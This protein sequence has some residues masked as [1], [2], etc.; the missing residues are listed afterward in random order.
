MEGLNDRD[1]KILGQYAE[2]GNRE[3][4]WNYLA[5]TRGNDGYG[6]LALGVVRNDNMPGAV[7]NIYAENQARDESGRR[8]TEREWDAFGQDLVRRDFAARQKHM[9][10]GD[11]DLAL[12]LPVKDVQ[13]VHDGAFKNAGITPDAWT[14]RQLLEAARRHGGEEAADGVWNTMLDSSRLGTTRLKET[15]ISTAVRY[16]DEKLDATAYVL[17]LSAASTQAALSL[18]NTNPNRVGLVNYYHFYDKQDKHWYT[19]NTT[20]RAF[21]PIGN[22]VA[23]QQITD[24]KKLD[25][26]NDIR[27]LR[28]ERQERAKDFHPS[29]PHRTLAQSPKTLADA[30]DAVGPVGP[31]AG[32]RQAPT[33]AANARESAD[34]LFE[35]LTD[36]AMSKDMDGMRTVGR[37]FRDSADGQQ[38]LRTGQEHNQA[39]RESQRTVELAA[40]APQTPAYEAP[41]R[42]M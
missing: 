36:A 39:E 22:F 42:R 12:N 9:A 15:L 21:G 8:L 17:R 29:D 33:Y 31:D 6:L 25:E 27:A 5:Q 23:V 18:D 19:E 37:D 10:H 20:L 35:R 7:A 14:P 4:Y 28:Q 1:M 41:V 11:S 2:K 30:G 38:W 40:L 3:L 32:Q 34:K 26:L 13:A 16:N 24:P